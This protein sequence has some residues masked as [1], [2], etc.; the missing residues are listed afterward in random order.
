MTDIIGKGAIM[1]PLWAACLTFVAAICGPV[2]AG[3]FLLKGKR[4]DGPQ[5]ALTSLLNN[6]P[7]LLTKAQDLLADKAVLQDK[8]R[9]RDGQ[10]EDLGEG[11]RELTEKVAALDETVRRLTAQADRVPGLEAEN[12]ARR[13]EIRQ[14]DARIERLTIERDVALR[15]QERAEGGLRATRQTIIDITC[16]EDGSQYED[17]PPFQGPAQVT[18]LNTAPDAPTRS[19]EST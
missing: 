10:I 17:G 19:P 14:R 12:A 15:A 16:A 13:G 4:V 11:I 3:W 18:P 5:Q 7:A 1:I 6:A 2:I 9:E 8:L